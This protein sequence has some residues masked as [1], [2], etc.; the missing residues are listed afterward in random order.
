MKNNYSSWA[1]RNIFLKMKDIW[2][3]CRLESDTCSPHKYRVIPN[4]LIE[5]NVEMVR[6]F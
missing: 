6:T 1:I 2:V 5:Q 3:H 4:I